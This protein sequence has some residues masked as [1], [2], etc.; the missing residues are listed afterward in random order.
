MTVF[1]LFKIE[2]IVLKIIVREHCP[3]FERGYGFTLSM[4]M[5]FELSFLTHGQSMEMLSVVSVKP[6]SCFYFSM[7]I[8][9]MRFG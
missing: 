6:Q 9:K 4:Y 5:P 3:H 1:I 8:D 2:N 7:L